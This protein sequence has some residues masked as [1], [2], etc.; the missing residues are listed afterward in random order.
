MPAEDHTSYAFHPFATTLGLKSM[1]SAEGASR[2][3]LRI[4]ENL[5]NPQRVAHGAVAFALADTTMGGALYTTLKTGEICSTI[6][7]KINYFRP[8]RE[9]EVLVRETQLVHRG[10]T[11]AVLESKITAGDKLAAKALGTYA[12]SQSKE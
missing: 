3:E 2:A 8:V 9:G 1:E 4:T 11:T 7:I 5:L 6:E 10:R 12:I